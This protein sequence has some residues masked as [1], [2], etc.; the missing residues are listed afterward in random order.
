[1][2]K[3]QEIISKLTD[4]QKV[5]ILTGLSSLSGK[6]FEIL[7]L[8]GL[9]AKNIKDYGRDKYPSA[10]ALAHAWDEEL[11]QK[12]ADSRAELAA[13]DGADLLISPGAKIKLSPYRKEVS[14]DPYFASVFSASQLRGASHHGLKCALSGYYLTESDAAF[15]DT[16]PSDRVIEEFVCEPYK[17][18]LALGGSDYVITDERPLPIEY[19]DVS[20]KLQS[21]L[22]GSSL[23]CLKAG[24]DNTVKFI[25]RGI[26]CL[27]ASQTAL[28]AAILRYK[29]LKSAEARGE[30]VTP[31]QIASEEKSGLAIS[32][33]ALDIAVDRALSFLSECQEKRNSPKKPADANLS[34]DAS[35]RSAVLLKNNKKVLPL[36]Y[37][38]PF[39]LIG[40]ILAEIKN[41]DSLLEKTYRELDRRGYNCISTARGYMPGDFSG[42]RLENE[43]LA[44][45]MRA[46]VVVLFLGFGHENEKKVQS[47]ELL[48]LP[49]NQLRLARKLIK[50]G[51]T[52]IGVIESGH[53]P[54][55]A[56]T[57]NFSAVLMMPFSG[58]GTPKAIADILTGDR[59]P[60]GKLAYTLYAE[61]EQAFNKR[62]T[63]KNHYGL[64]SGPFIGY[65]YYDTA[66]VVVGY[67]F[68][69]GL[70]YSSF[71]YS[72]LSYKG[73]T[74]SFT[75]K[76]TGNTEAAEIP[77]IYIGKESSQVL[78]PKKELCGFTR[79]TLKPGETKRISIK[80]EP[81]AVRQNGTS[82]TEDGTYTLY[83]GSS[84]SDIRLYTAIRI[85]G[86]I[87]APDNE[88][89]IDY[90]QS[91]PNVKED[92]FTL[93]A[94][95]S[96]MKSKSIKNVFFGLG[97]LLIAISLATFMV[98]TETMS[99]F[100]G[101]L[102]GLTAI[103]A[104][105]FF[106]VAI[107]ERSQH[108]AAERER[109]DKLNEVHFSTAEEL[110]APSAELMFRE[111]FDAQSEEAEAAAEIEES[112]FDETLRKYVNAD[113]GISELCD[114]LSDY[115]QAHGLKPENG[116]VNSIVT[117]LMTSR[118]L[119]L[120]GIS[121][122]DFNALMVILSEY[123]GTRTYVETVEDNVKEAHELLFAYDHHDDHAKKPATLALEES[124][125]A[126]EKLHLLGLDGIGAECIEHLASPFSKYLLSPREKNEI[127]IYNENGANVGFTI[128]NNL[129]LILRPADVV[130][131]EQLP[132]SLL[133]GASCVVAS[134]V[135]CPA[136]A[137][138]PQYHGCNRHQLDYIN[139]MNN[140][141]D[142]ITEDTYKRIDK[143]EAYAAEHAEFGIGNKLWLAVEKQLGL[144][145]ASGKEI[146][147]ALDITVS[148][149][150]LPA[151][152]SAL[153]GKLTED[154][155]SIKDKINFI[156]GE[157]YTDLC[158]KLLSFITAAY[159]YAENY[160]A[161]KAAEAAAREKAEAEAKAAAEARAKAEA[162]ARERA[163]AELRA[164]EEA[165]ARAKEEAIAKARAMAE[166]QIREEAEAKARAKAEA[167]AKAAAEA[168]AAA[169]AEAEAR[170]EAAKEAARAMEEAEARVKAAEMARALAEAS[171]KE[172]ETIA[173][174]SGKSNTSDVGTDNKQ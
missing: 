1:M 7:G 162:V 118:L 49:A 52:V 129:R 43:A 123:F 17:R 97:S 22:S 23:I 16:V 53:A 107:V 8:S 65:R 60:S 6:D 73:S 106:V 153:K 75:L 51:K 155:E 167:E 143:L 105:Q 171:A 88:R 124:P 152:C 138:Y 40:G 35:V 135:K 169:M 90:I 84:V 126:P 157:E 76:N 101:I 139:A 5:R 91:I 172:A 9:N 120:E 13:K 170:A 86:E 94:K 149:K 79:V 150:I 113:F 25:S 11:W 78:R 14:E 119:I 24:N 131:I 64:R 145:L 45:A 127:I 70:S 116:V 114:E 163:I 42:N 159:E 20:D 10:G 112:Y 121:S 154:D 92:N 147:E 59:S 63:Y 110:A 103:F 168:A 108:E 151:I 61:S 57:R 69:H 165:K 2:L 115:I 98:V 128:A 161:H 66:D 21:E 30:G 117:S 104:I 125:T 142:T 166:A 133:R 174:Q 137:E 99:V 38:T 41:G 18:A 146:Y 102:A 160:E 89:V 96:P 27:S 87:I 141:A 148:A 54:D 95:Y 130:A 31:E 19:R 158:T 80:I 32:G 77:Q 109:I 68:G 55:I 44:L 33:E 136:A 36:S 34:A 46:S 47:N 132:V 122:E 71:E 67:P 39:V 48:T 56:F 58:E 4:A 26:I 85:K 50:S 72:D 93:E 100:L 82:K 156:F 173:A 83:V 134:F 140:L 29:K 12:V 37:Q 74:V 28:E 81:P 3:N 111:E 15:M 62:K 144:L 164:E